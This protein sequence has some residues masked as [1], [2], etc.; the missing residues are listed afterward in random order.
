VLDADTSLD[1]ES[2]DKTIVP[3]SESTQALIIEA[4]Q[5]STLFKNMEYALQA[6]ICILS[7]NQYIVRLM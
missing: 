2:F 5:N 4:L 1:D 6:Y 3:K 7:P